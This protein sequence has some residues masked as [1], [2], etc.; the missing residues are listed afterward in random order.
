MKSMGAKMHDPW[1][2]KKTIPPTLKILMT[3]RCSCDCTDVQNAHS[4]VL[5]NID[6]AITYRGV[7][8]KT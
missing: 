5:K 8:A 3:D 7:K 6:R 2:N 4:S 1:G